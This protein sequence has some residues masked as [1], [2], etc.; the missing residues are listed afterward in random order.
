MWFRKSSP[1]HVADQNLTELIVAQWHVIS[2]YYWT[3]CSFFFPN[4]LQHVHA[5]VC[6]CVCVCMCNDS[7][8]VMCVRIFALLFSCNK[9]SKKYAVN[10]DGKIR[11]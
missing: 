3:V 2:V 4:T 11:M 7:T 10:V 6:V 8:P 9:L 5:F 1:Y